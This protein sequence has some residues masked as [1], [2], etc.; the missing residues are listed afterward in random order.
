MDWLWA[1]LE[2]VMDRVRRITKRAVK[3]PPSHDIH[4]TLAAT[5]LFEF[6]RTGRSECEAYIASLIEACDTPLAVHELL[7][8]LHPL[9]AGGWLT[10]SA[11]SMRTGH[12]NFS[13]AS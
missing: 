11:D 1:E 2:A 12:G 4:Q 9:R 13:R 5:H 6:L 8:Q 3:A 10:F 7:P